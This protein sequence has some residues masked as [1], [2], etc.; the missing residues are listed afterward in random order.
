MSVLI[1][2]AL[3]V[4]KYNG[5]N[6]NKNVDFSGATTVA[7]PAGTTIAGTTAQGA[8]TLTSTSAT[9]FT[10]GANGATNPVFNINANTASVATGV[11]VVGAATGAGVAVTATDSGSDTALILNSKGTSSLSL[12]AT[13]TG[14]VVVGHGLVGTTNTLTGSGAISLTTLTTKLNTTGGGAITLADGV[15]GQL[16]IVT[17][18]VDGGDATITPAT[19]TGYTTCVFD[20]A[21]DSAMFVF[22]TTRGW[23]CVATNGGVLS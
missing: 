13:A 9:A 21:G 1:E 15:D 2:D 12:N 14:N 23:M 4:V 3:P 8:T 22:V 5:L 6:T 10:V 7:L 11:T 16:K 17:L 19:K 18:D 20:N